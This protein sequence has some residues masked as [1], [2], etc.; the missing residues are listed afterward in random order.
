MNKK[1]L[2]LAIKNGENL[3]KSLETLPD[4]NGVTS[5]LHF[6]YTYNKVTKCY[7]QHYTKGSSAQVIDTFPNVSSLELYRLVKNE[8]EEEIIKAKWG[9]K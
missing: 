6:E 3:S 7:S 8:S 9:K 1:E 4:S 2:L 5:L